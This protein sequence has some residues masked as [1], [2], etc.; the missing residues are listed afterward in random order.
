MRSWSSCNA[1]GGDTVRQLHA[2]PPLEAAILLTATIGHLRIDLASR[3][4]IKLRQVQGYRART[5]ENQSGQWVH[6]LRKGTSIEGSGEAAKKHL[7]QVVTCAVN[8]VG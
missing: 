6:S 3:Q 1:C 4:S 2:A 7:E 5:S 8:L